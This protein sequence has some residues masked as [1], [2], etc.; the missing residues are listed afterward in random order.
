MIDKVA[1]AGF[2]GASSCAIDVSSIE[3]GSSQLWNEIG[4]SP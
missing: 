4:S 2:T 1:D 3:N